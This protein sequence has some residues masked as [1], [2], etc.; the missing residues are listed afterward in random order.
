M[1]P[2]RSGATSA[3]QGRALR[4]ALPA[5][6]AAT[7]RAQVCLKVWGVPR[8]LSSRGGGAGSGLR[9]QGWPGCHGPYCPPSVPAG[10]AAVWL[11]G[12]RD[13]P[14]ALALLP[15]APFSPGGPLRPGRPASPWKGLEKSASRPS[16]VGARQEPARTGRPVRLQRWVHQMRARSEGA[17]CLGRAVLPAGPE[18]WAARRWVQS[19]GHPRAWPRGPCEAWEKVVWL[20]GPLGHR[21]AA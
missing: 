16:G 20:L 17:A 19:S 21:G 3:T 11:G 18:T 1:V 10:R 5:S 9:A 8:S 7:G 15:L 14:G 2:L 4:T 12:S 6:P 13:P